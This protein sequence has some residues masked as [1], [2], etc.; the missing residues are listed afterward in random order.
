VW[1]WEHILVAYIVS[2]VFWQLVVGKPLPRSAGF[3]AVSGALLPDIVDKPLSWS[4]AILPTG[5]SLAHSVITCVVLLA[6]T[7]PVAVGRLRLAEWTGFAVGYLTHLAGDVSYGLL[8]G[9]PVDPGFL[10][11]PLVAVETT[12][13]PGLVQTAAQFFE[14]YVAFLSTPRGMVYLVVELVMI[15][16]G[17][18]LWV[19]DGRE[20][21]QEPRSTL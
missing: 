19:H 4:L 6:V 7:Y 17:I 2:S 8:V 9:R 20:T 10:L 3:A 13:R 12:D 5:T 1:P 18:A 16:A 15:A 11:W 14:F 21:K